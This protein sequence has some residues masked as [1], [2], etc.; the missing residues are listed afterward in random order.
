EAPAHGLI[1][2]LEVFTEVRLMPYATDRE[3]AGGA[4]QLQRRHDECALSDGYRR[5]FARVPLLPHGAQL[6]LF[7]R[8]QAFLLVGKVDSGGMTEAGEASVIREVVDP[9]LGADSIKVHVAG[10]DHTA[11]E[12]HRAVPA[13]LP[14]ALVFSIKRN[15]AGAVDRELVVDGA[16]FES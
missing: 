14:A 1:G 7:R 4:R 9:G 16:G 2:F 10:V 3:T 13:R 11:V 12:R 5:R 15:A 6:P 8:H